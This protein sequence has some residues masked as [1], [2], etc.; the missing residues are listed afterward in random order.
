[1]TEFAPATTRREALDIVA[2]ALEAGGFDHARREARLVVQTALGIDAGELLARPEA[3]LGEGAARL[4][5]VLTRRLAHEPL[6]RIAGRREFF[7]LDFALSAGTLDPRP[8]T[9]VLVEAALDHASRRGMG[10]LPIRIVDLGVGSGAILAALLTRLPLA[11]GVGVDRSADALAT[12]RLNVERHCG[13]GRAA[14]LASDWFDRVEGRFDMI[15]SNP[16]Y[17]PTR[18][19]TGLD[20][21]VRLYDPVAAL[22]GGPDGLDA[23]RALATALPHRLAAGGFAAFEVGAGQAE[24]VAALIAAQGLS[25]CEIRADLAGIDRVVVAAIAD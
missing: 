18:D 3:I 7:G 1:V 13:A 5:E 24:A 9:E 11:T 19:L 15:V 23:Y 6:T 4:A 21:E 14:F 22:D 17:I 8:D 25:V 16:P 2:R 12:A 10:A 20:P